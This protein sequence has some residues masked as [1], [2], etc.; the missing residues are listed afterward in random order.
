MEINFV[1]ILILFVFVLAMQLWLLRRSSMDI[2][3]LTGKLE[4]LQDLQERTDR[5]VRNE[6]SQFRAEMQNQAHQERAE[7]A[8]SLK[9]F[10]DSVQARMAE[11]AVLQRNQLEGFASRLAELTATNEQKMNAL[12]TV[13]DEKLKQLQEDNNRQLDRMRDTVDEKLQSTL[14]KR[15]SESFKQV[16][17][18]LERVHQGLGD[19]RSL[20]ADVGDLGKVL[21]NV[22]LRGTWGEV[23][24]GAILEELLAP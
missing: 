21:K 23:Q 9:S 19:M 4:T 6:I 2:S 22:K 12:R 24:L 10:G 16:S 20:A 14:E 8:G 13:V 1:I 5:S 11:I 15:L 3:P 7:L 17:E 18:R